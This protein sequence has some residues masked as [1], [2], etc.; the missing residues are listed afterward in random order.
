MPSIS[1]VVRLDPED[2]RPKFDCDDEDL[3]DFFLTDSCAS[4]S[5]LLS[6]TYLA[7]NTKDETLAF[8]SVS[9]DSIKK[10]SLTGSRFKRVTKKIPREKRYSSM[11]AVKI[12]RLG[13]NKLFQRQGIGTELLDFIKFWFT[14]GNKTGCRFVI[15]DAY[16]KDE[17]TNFYKRNGFEYLLTDDDKDPTRLMYFDLIT[18]R[19]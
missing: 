9:N 18:F 14:H 2:S 7:T 10:E 17:V 11:P 8:F 12:G 19:E 16:N 1:K 5:E 6:V 4:G 3:N 13:T 15:V